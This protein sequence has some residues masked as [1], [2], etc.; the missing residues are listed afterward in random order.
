MIKK[1]TLC[2]LVVLSTLTTIRAASLFPTNSTWKYMKGTAEASSPD[3]ATWRGLGFDDSTWASGAAPFYY[4][5]DTN[6]STAYTGNTQLAD[7]Q[8]NYTCI[9]L[10]KTFAVSDPANFA[11]LR[12]T[13]ICDDG[14]IVWVN[15]REIGR[16]NMPAGPVAFNGLSSA[17]LG[18]PIAGF[19]ITTNNPADFLV[20]GNNVI[21][22]QAFNSSLA[23]SSDF[24]IDAALSSIEPDS[25]PPVVFQVTPASGAIVSN[26]T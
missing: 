24:T 2:A 18:E 10:R 8:G 5:T 19:S 6:P 22:I 3:P 25:I 4:D 1:L 23:G 13:G 7:M 15:G 12:L 26:L 20:A 16:Y 11:A 17:A 9:F 14:F 21:C